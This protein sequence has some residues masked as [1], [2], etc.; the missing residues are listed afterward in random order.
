M[1]QSPNSDLTTEG[2]RVRAAAQYLAHESMPDERQFVFA[3]KV[4]IQNNAVFIDRFV[5]L[6]GHQFNHGFVG[7]QFSRIQNRFHLD[8][9][10]GLI[11]DILSE[12]ISCR[13]MGKL[14]MRAD[15]FGL[16]SF[17]GSGRTEQND[18]H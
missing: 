11:F 13:E 7:D 1:K 5:Q 4:V 3:Y 14:K 17:S 9:K 12:N 6:V 15:F 8:S 2:I 18:I 10:R 16:R